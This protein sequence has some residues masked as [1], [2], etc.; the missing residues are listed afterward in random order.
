MATDVDYGD[1]PIETPDQDLFGVTPFI[2]A[3]SRSISKML[4][5]KGVVVALNGPWGSGK[6]SAINLLQHN[7]RATCD[8]Q[9]IKIVQFN[10]WWFRGEEALVL[11]FLRELYAATE[12]SLSA[13]AKQLLPKLGARL[14]KAGSFVAPAAD[15]A[16]YAGAGKVAAGAM[17]WLGG[18]IEDRESV[19]ALHNQLASALQ[20]QPTRFLV[21]IDDIDR[22]APDEALAMFRLV[23]SVGRLPNVIYVLAFDRLLAERVVSEKF[24]SEG[25]HYLEKIV[26]ASFEL[27]PPEPEDLRNLLLTKI[28]EIAGMPEDSLMVHFMNLFHE[29]VSPEIDTPRDVFRY[30]NAF[31]ITWPAVAGEVDLG[32]FVALEAYRLFHPRIY[33]GIRDNSAMLLQATQP[34]GNQKELAAAADQALLASAEDKVRFRRGIMRLFPLTESVW[35]N[36][37]HGG[38]EQE[39]R[40]QRRVSSREHFASYFRFSVSDGNL[41]HAAL[42]AILA[43]ASDPQWVADRMVAA[44][45]EI[46]RNGQSRVPALLNGLMLHAGEVD[47][48]K[49]AA[50]LT[51]LFSV[52]DVIDTENDQ[53]KG[54][55]V[56]TNAHR[57]HWLLRALLLKRTTLAER[58]AILMR[59]L[60]GASLSWFVNLAS[61]AWDHYHPNEGKEAKEEDGCLLTP[62]DSARTAKEAVR[63]ITAA[64]RDG[65]LIEHQD[66]TYLIFNWIHF[67]TDDGRAARR[68]IGAR[69]RE[70]NSLV[71]LAGAFTSESWSHGIGGAAGLGDLVARRND[72][73]SV[74]AIG[75]LVDP[76][77][78]RRRLESLTK[79]LDP[80]SDDHAKVLRFLNAWPSD[81]ERED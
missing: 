8:E 68:W 16:G 75:K 67:S 50:M 12:P 49:A 25:P 5:P 38:I 22:L 23:K 70:D 32:D 54:F 41:S 66:L 74:A 60:A 37:L 46:R 61:S 76:L 77:D 24:P 39:W 28:F 7:L 42:D 40:R 43:N 78:F 44:S 14:L 30:V 26:Q 4:S 17:T 81:G 62:R 72:R 29:I 59:A 35:S 48:E 15:L 36:V 80:S 58:S 73:V 3:L 55:D 71:H 31:S 56:G 9:D 27:H 64:S 33:Q 63:R 52:A 21:I 20:A 10:P 69:L 51:G 53:A 65:T 11:A 34:W 57:I 13:K 79:R 47:L 19:E 45:K 2:E 18:L 1:L 6:S